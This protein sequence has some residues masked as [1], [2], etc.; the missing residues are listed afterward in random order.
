VNRQ[1]PFDSCNKDGAARFDGNGAK[2]VNYDPS[3]FG[4]RT[5]DSECSERT[6]LMNRLREH[7]IVHAHDTNAKRGTHEDLL[8][9]HLS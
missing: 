6:N 7:A 8:W 4:G 1:C 5:Q 2:T 3:R 9:H